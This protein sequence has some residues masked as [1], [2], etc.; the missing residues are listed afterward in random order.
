VRLQLNPS[1]TMCV[2]LLFLEFRSSRVMMTF[3][4]SMSLT[5]PCLLQFLRQEW[6]TFQTAIYVH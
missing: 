5:C 1:M 4:V 6:S 3:R 2:S